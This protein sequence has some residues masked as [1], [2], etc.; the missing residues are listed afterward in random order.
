MLS[1][2][3]PKEREVQLNACQI[4]D[5]LSFYLMASHVHGLYR[6]AR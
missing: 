1:L 5:I 6:Q 4:S 3:F 2:R